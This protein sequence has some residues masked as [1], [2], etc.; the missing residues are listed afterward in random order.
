LRLSADD[1]IRVDARS[2]LGSAYQQLHDPANAKEN[3][4]AALR[5][6][7]NKPAAL[8]GMGLLSQKSGDLEQAIAQYSHA[9]SV[10]PTAVG[11][12]LLARALDQAGHPTEA[13]AALDKAR[14]LTSDL[15]EAQQAADHLLT[16]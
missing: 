15:A 4:A 11:Y 6:D 1:A 2:N 3:F 9:V 7:P 5:L 8:L 14:Q 12:V 10:A 13:K 16:F